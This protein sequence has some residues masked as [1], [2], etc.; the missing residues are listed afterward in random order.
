MLTQIVIL[1]NRGDPSSHARQV[2]RAGLRITHEISAFSLRGDG[3]GEH[4]SPARRRTRM[5]IAL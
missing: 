1:A 5:A 2:A 3:D 4:E